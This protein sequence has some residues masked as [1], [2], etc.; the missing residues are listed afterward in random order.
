MTKKNIVSGKLLFFCL[1]LASGTVFSAVPDTLVQ[2]VTS[3][4][5]TYT[6]RMTK[7][8]FRGPNFEVLVQNSSGDYDPYDAGE[9]RTYLG[10]VDEDF[11]AVVAGYLR[12]DG[13]L[14]AAIFFDRGG[15]VL[16]RGQ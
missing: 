2:S 12:T 6:L 9:V 7:Q 16:H 1:L 11:S 10:T 8:N 4:S 13:V 3:G 15:T 14:R 5:N